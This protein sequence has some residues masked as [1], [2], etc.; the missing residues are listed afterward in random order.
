[1]KSSEWEGLDKDLVLDMLKHFLAFDLA[2][3]IPARP[4][5]FVGSKTCGWD[6]GRLAGAAVT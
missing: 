1:M 5:A 3:L 2:A 6:K 4:K